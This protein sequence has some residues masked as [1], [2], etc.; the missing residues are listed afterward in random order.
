MEKYVISQKI[1]FKT[2]T[3]VTKAKGSCKG[4]I[5]LHGSNDSYYLVHH[6]V[7]ILRPVQLHLTNGSSVVLAGQ[8]SLIFLCRHL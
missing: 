2:G 1:V 3:M 4:G 5:L 6:L 7:D 8:Y